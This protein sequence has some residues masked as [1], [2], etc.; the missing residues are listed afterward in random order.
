MPTS[1]KTTTRTITYTT[2][3]LLSAFALVNHASAATV[4]WTGSGGT[5]KNWST[6]ANWDTN[7]PVD[8]V[9]DVVLPFLATSTSNHQ[10]IVDSNLSITGLTLN[11]AG[12]PNDVVEMDINSGITLTTTDLTLS[13]ANT[14]DINTNS[15]TGDMVISGTISNGGLIRV[16]GGSVSVTNTGENLGDVEMTGGSLGI[17]AAD[18]T[19]ADLT[20]SGGD[21]AIGTGNNLNVSPTT[22]STTY[23]GTI[24]GAGTLTKQGANTLVLAGNNTHTGDTILEAGQLTIGSTNAL[25]TGKLVAE[26]GTSLAS[27]GNQTIANDIEIDDS[28]ASTLTF[29]GTGNLTTNGTLTIGATNGS[30]ID[31]NSTGQLIAAGTTA[32]GDLIKEGTGTIRF[33]GTIGHN[34]TTIN[35][36]KAIFD[37][38]TTG[39]TIS[40]GGSGQALFTSN[41][42]R[43]GTIGLDANTGLASAGGTDDTEITNDLNIS[44]DTTI[45]SD[46]A[47]TLSGDVDFNDANITI[48]MAGAQATTFT[49]AFSNTT[50][51]LTTTG[52]GKLVLNSATQYTG[53]V[54]TAGSLDIMNAGIGGD[55]TIGANATLG[56]LSDTAIASTA[57]LTARE[58]VTVTLDADRT[59]AAGTTVALENAGNFDIIG[60]NTLTIEGNVTTDTTGKTIRV[61]TAT[62]AT[63]NGTMNAT[64]EL[65]L[66]SFGSAGLEFT[67]TITATD[68]KV[69]AAGTGTVTL[70][71]TVNSAVEL[72]GG[73]L[74]G[75]G[76]I[77]GNVVI[78]GGTH[79]VGNSV[80]TL[81]VTGDYTLAAGGT[82]EAEINTLDGTNDN[83]DA[84]GTIT[85]A[86]NSSI[87]V[88]PINAGLIADGDTFTLFTA[89]TFIDNGANVTTSSAFY[90]FAGAKHS[91]LEQ[92]DITATVIASFT[93]VSTGS[94][95]NSVSSALEDM[96]GSSPT[97][98]QTALLGQLL[99][100]N[101]ADYNKNVRKLSVESHSQGASQSVSQNRTNF[102]QVAG[103]LSG[104]RGGTTFVQRGADE[105]QFAAMADNPDLLMLSTNA[106][107]LEK[108]KPDWSA[109]GKIFAQYTKQDTEADILGFQ[110]E[111]GGIVLGIDRNFTKNC[112]GGIMAGYAFSDVDYS[113][114]RGNAKINSFR[115]G[116]YGSYYSEDGWYVDASL[117]FGY[118]DN[119]TERNVIIGT[120]SETN[121][122]DYNAWDVSMYTGAGYDY[123]F[124][125]ITI[126]PNAWLQYSYY[127]QEEFTETG[128][129]SATTVESYSTSSLRSMIGMKFSKVFDHNT[130][131]YMPEVNIG[132]GHEWLDPDDI[133]ARFVGEINPFSFTPGMFN[134]NSLL[135]SAGLSAL[136]DER[137]SMF[138][139]YDGDISNTGEAHAA[140]FGM[141]WNF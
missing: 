127:S 110:G 74:M 76:A 8:T 94:N 87:D 98:D 4:T 29:D 90:T 136:I 86:N 6:N 72:L 101:T 21:I 50:G 119:N 114:N 45:Q 89:G 113:D 25:G 24:S 111:T 103:R 116:P 60:G 31:V 62:N 135:I 68:L 11:A 3:A 42:N 35:D 125:G 139:K 105:L 99:A 30:T 26:D 64:G 80:G 52:T 56:L 10:N 71:G 22:A 17:D 91:T 126:T 95:N 58:N 82:F 38:D 32:G 120:V 44:A 117:L 84:T 9:D 59:L 47:M 65:G 109:W 108:V 14:F 18:L 28:V 92:Y 33:G 20:G 16:N 118:N 134:E 100:M 75:D 27:N 128:G 55:V 104:V 132:W 102:N 66:Q 73:T 1:T 41:A 130:V 78:T 13:S 63:F 81:N 96:Q 37:T 137:T 129:A 122:A 12:D 107:P 141:R 131:R 54:E 43:V 39:K 7:A 2:A 93:D 88:V 140:S 85:L 57:T 15:G 123:E 133:E 112:I 115:V 19:I 121:E 23:S 69:N 53:D 51:K 40:T 46:R 49:G 124:G 138:F 97:T 70:N 5:D 83:V 77:N 36:G 34:S 79:N 106:R 67:N 61:D 48:D